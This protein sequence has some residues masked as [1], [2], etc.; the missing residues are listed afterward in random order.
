MLIRFTS[1]GCAAAALALALTA[2]A[3]AHADARTGAETVAAPKI[4]TYNVFMLSRNLYP[5]WGQ[6][7]R[8]DLIDSQNV[9]AG[10][11]VVVFEEAFDNDASTRLLANVADSY[12]YQTP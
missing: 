11:D 8:A 2:P 4:A 12:P 7:T 9:V 1:A 3:A 5:N 6:L 10:Q